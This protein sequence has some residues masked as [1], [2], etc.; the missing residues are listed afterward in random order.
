MGAINF[1][2]VEGYNL[3]IHYHKD[4]SKNLIHLLAEGLLDRLKDGNQKQK[5]R[6]SVSCCKN[7][8]VV[9][10]SNK[11]FVTGYFHKST[12]LE[13]DHVESNEEPVKETGSQRVMPAA[14]FYIDV[15]NHNIYWITKVGITGNPTIINFLSFLKNT[16]TD[17]LVGQYSMEFNEKYKPKI[18]GRSTKKIKKALTEFLKENKVTTAEFKIELV[19][20][21]PSDMLHKFFTRKYKI[22]EIVL[23]PKKSNPKKK[24]FDDLLEKA[25]DTFSDANADVEI[26]AKASNSKEGMDQKKLEK[27]VSKTLEEGTLLLKMKVKEKNEEEKGDF[28]VSNMKLSKK[29][30]AGQMD[31]SLKKQYKEKFE[32]ID[33][34]NVIKDVSKNTTKRIQEVGR[35]A[36]DKLL[37]IIV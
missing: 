18:K 4:E 1:I 12:K 5:F 22:M 10:I 35:V 11:K 23:R 3:L 26:K 24:D 29:E 15:E 21:I 32:K 28:I 13:W 14:R 19:P 16:S 9:S 36:L 20:L 31:I 37:E 17:M 8:K 2:R 30:H 33:L 27:A 34:A 7:V 25:E 6:A